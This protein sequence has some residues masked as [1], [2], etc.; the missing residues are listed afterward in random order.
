M[1]SFLP[2]DREERRNYVHTPPISPTDVAETAQALY[3]AL[4]L[5][6]ADRHTKEVLGRQIMERHDLTTWLTRQIH[7]LN[8]VLDGSAFAL[9][10]VERPDPPALAARVI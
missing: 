3:T 10:R 6:A 8:A 7:D 9:S 5:P 4:T 2:G 1:K